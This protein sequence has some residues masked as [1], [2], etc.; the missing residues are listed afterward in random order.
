MYREIYFHQYCINNVGDVARLSIR[1]RD[2]RGSAR[3]VEAGPIPF[4][5]SIVDS[6]DDAVGGIYPT[7]AT[8]QLISGANFTVADIYT[9]DDSEFQI[10]H[11]INEKVDWIGFLTPEGFNELDTNSYRYI[12]IRC[13]DGLTRLKDLKFVN[14][15]GQNYGVEDGVFQMSILSFIKEGLKKTANPLDI[16]TLVDRAA[17]ILSQASQTYKPYYVISRADDFVFSTMFNSLPED[18]IKVGNYISYKLESGSELSSKIIEID[19]SDV[20][21]G[22]GT[23]IK[24]A[25]PMIQGSGFDIQA[26]FFEPTF[27][28]SKDALVI[29]TADVRTWI[30]TDYQLEAVG[31]EKEKKKYY[32]EYLDGTANAWDVLN[33]IA[34]AFDVRI[35]QNNGCWTVESMDIHRV[36]AEYYRYN[37]QGQFVDRVSKEVV[38]DLSSCNFTKVKHKR[39]G[40]SKYIDKTLKSVSVGYNYKH[41][42]EGDPLVNL[43]KN[44]LFSEGTTIQDKFNFTPLFW[45]RFSTAYAIRFGIERAWAAIDKPYVEL[46]TPN[47]FNSFN[48]LRPNAAI[49]MSQGEVLKMSW[50]QSIKEYNYDRS[51]GSLWHVTMVIRL[52]TK[53]NKVYYLVNHEDEE[54][55]QD[56]DF[57][58]GNP[59]GQWVRDDKYVWHFNSNY[60]TQHI[61]NAGNIG[62]PGSAGVWSPMSEVKL[63]SNDVPEDG[64]LTI[65]FV[66][67]ARRTYS[68]RDKNPE[69]FARSYRQDGKQEDKVKYIQNDYS[70]TGNVTF[71]KDDYNPS[72]RVANVRLFKIT[73]KGNGRLYTY[74][75]EGNYFDIMDGISIPIGDE[76]N[77]DHISVLRVNGEVNNRWVTRDNSLEVSPLG[78]LLAK[79]IMRRYYK[80]KA[81]IDGAVS[82]YPTNLSG[83][84]LYDDGLLMTPISGDVSS[85]DHLLNGTF[86]Q[87]PMWE[88]PDGGIDH[89]PNSLSQ[90]RSSSGSSGSGFGGGNIFIP[91][92][93]V[94]PNTEPQDLQS[95]TAIGNETDSDLI[96]KGTRNKDLLA[97]PIAPVAV[98][99][100]IAGEMYLHAKDGY[101]FLNNIKANAGYSDNAGRWD[102]V[103]RSEYLTQP[104]RSSDNVA[105]AGITATNFLRIPQVANAA[106]DAL[107]KSGSYAMLGSA[108]VWAGR[109]DLWNGYAQPDYLDQPVR[110][111][112]SPVFAG[113]SSPSFASGF[114]GHGY[115]IGKDANGKYMAEFD[116]LTVRQ[117]FNVYE[118]IVNQLRSTNGSLI[119]SDG[120]KITGATPS[121]VNYLCTI[122]TDG[123]TI[124]VPFRVDDILQ[125]QVY[126]GSSMKYF[127]ARVIA[128]NSGNFTINIIDGASIPEEGDD[129]VRID[130]FTDANRKGIVY[131][132]ASD[133]GAP[134]IDTVYGKWTDPQNSVRVRIG[135]LDGIVDADLGALSGYGQYT[136]NGYFKGIFQVQNGSNVYTKTQADGNVS[137]AKLEAISAAASDASS[138]ANSA[139]DAAINS[140]NQF[141]Q[142]AVISINI[143]ARNRFSLTQ[144]PIGIANVTDF[145]IDKSN[146]GFSLTGNSTPG[147]IR[148]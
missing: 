99:D 137:A 141:A 23:G 67:S 35:S 3:R 18:L 28:E 52:I 88:L 6:A 131:I 140:A 138:K 37:Y 21:S 83:L 62:E 30:G 139:R 104:V 136:Q 110:A 103:L 122:D 86:R 22:G 123:G 8:L 27:D 7:S 116:R 69:D 70:L 94:T 114:T 95:V 65:S 117:D 40:N 81:M 109:A 46:T 74:S 108:K 15:K 58:S 93:P 39:S 59:I 64:D 101:T 79:S 36:S 5:K 75:Q 77:G 90:N 89:G 60:S 61:R 49:Q 96:T 29:T 25:R 54:G 143:G 48:G 68:N 144:T 92:P 47:Q 120:I 71:K 106:T 26:Y 130:N 145:T 38:E 12:N 135:R 129:L 42:A 80:P 115:R 147:Y 105:F 44:H 125:T 50:Q 14:D 73:T 132:T 43:I 142:D 45:E 55:W 63:T 97:I 76:N 102:N 126:N 13:F 134:Y 112:D 148:M 119:V 118:L 41:K 87:L 82:F 20:S 17:V 51:L 2:Y 10:V 72:V 100:K 4:T 57:M 1:K 31:Q 128:V 53:T 98:D 111:N 124:G 85:K 127:V 24:L 113:I 107:W 16:L 34:L 121:G 11:T 32:Y 146:N 91:P 9:A 66:G 56:A 84:F 133:S 19:R 78:L 33:D